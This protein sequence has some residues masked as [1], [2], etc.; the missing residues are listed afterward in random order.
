MR[1]RSLLL[2]SCKKWQS[3]VAQL[4]SHPRTLGLFLLYDTSRCA[5]LLHAQLPGPQC[6][7][8]LLCFAGMTG[9]NTC[10]LPCG[11]VGWTGGRL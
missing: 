11:T 2:W 5:L 9:W 3:A 8:L 6:P 10:V 7:C 4:P 1:L